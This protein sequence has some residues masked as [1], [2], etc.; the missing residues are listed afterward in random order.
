MWLLGRI[1]LIRD[2]HSSMLALEDPI[3]ILSAISFPPGCPTS[4]L[5]TLI[6]VHE[7][8][9]CTLP[10]CA[11][12]A[13][14]TAL[15][16]WVRKQTRG[17]C[18]MKIISYMSHD[19]NMSI[20]FKTLSQYEEIT[21]LFTSGA[22]A[23][24]GDCLVVACSCWVNQL[25]VPSEDFLGLLISAPMSSWPCLMSRASGVLLARIVIS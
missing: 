2:F 3:G 1:S 12:F 20:S 9:R 11:M 16:T 15:W 25:L 13:F 18:S 4:P 19:D 14:D 6:D 5:L 24:I 10:W 17:Q 21:L 23:F 8:D 7:L 22:A